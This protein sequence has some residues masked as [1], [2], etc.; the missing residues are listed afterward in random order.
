MLRATIALLPLLLHAVLLPS[1]AAAVAPPPTTQQQPTG[2]CALSGPFYTA[3]TEGLSA[4]LATCEAAPRCGGFTWKSAAS[5]TGEPGGNCTG[6]VGQPCC[7]MQSA[8]AMGHSEPRENYTCWEKPPTPGAASYHVDRG[9][10][11][12]THFEHFWERGINSPHSALTL[13][14]DYQRQMTAL[15]SDI[16]YTYTRIHAPFARDYSVAQGPPLPDRNSSTVSYFNAFATYDFLLSIGMKPWIELGYTPCWMSGPPAVPTDSYWPTVDYGICVGSPR[17][18][19]LWTDLI[20]DYVGAMVGRYG[21]PEVES[22]VF[23]LFNEPGGINAFSKQWE[24]GNFSYYELFFN[25]SRAIKSHGAKIQVGGLSDGA[26]QAVKLVS[27]QEGRPDRAGAFDLFTF[28]AYT[29]YSRDR[30]PMRT[31]ILTEIC[32]TCVSDL[33]AARLIAVCHEVDTAMAKRRWSVGRDR[34]RRWQHC[35][36]SCRHP[37][38]SIWR[39]RAAQLGVTRPFMTRQGR[40]LLLCRT[41]MPCMQQV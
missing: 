41:S 19:Q 13:R 40:R 5:G 16:G 28:H 11:G 26:E 27:L 24:T 14:A 30:R 32:C 21:L 34:S 8:A 22:W 6:G 9:S 17:H 39:R 31:G 3:V 4:C 35:V 33:G 36:K 20:S 23:V 38:R 37:C 1:F 2:G 29:T 10:G 15:R 25:T 12:T 7:Y 18:M